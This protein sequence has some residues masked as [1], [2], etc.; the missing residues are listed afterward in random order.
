[1]A[2]IE[3]TDLRGRPLRLSFIPIEGGQRC[4]ELKT[5]NGTSTGCGQ[6]PWTDEGIQVHPTLMESMIFLNGSVAPEV[7]KLELPHEDGY[8][9]DLP[10]VERFVLH[11]IPQARF[12][13]GK[14]PV[15]L[16]ARGGDG[17]EIARE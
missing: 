11:D 8:V 13:E 7:T 15:L 2:M 3:T 17:A 4:V 9:I 16:V 6:G 1:M 14:R 12:E 10:I 5:R